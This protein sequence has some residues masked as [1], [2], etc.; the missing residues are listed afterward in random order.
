MK[1]RKV[2]LSLE[3]KTDFPIKTLKEIAKKFYPE[4]FEEYKFEVVQVQANVI[5]KEK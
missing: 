4:D 2:M 5:K 1:P 3:V